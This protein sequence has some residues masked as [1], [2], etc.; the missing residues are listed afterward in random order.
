[1]TRLSREDFF[2]HEK[3]IKLATNIHKK[4]K[5]NVNFISIREPV[6]R[7][8]L[9][10]NEDWLDYIGISLKIKDKKYIVIKWELP[11]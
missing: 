10:D 2:G 4:N 8:L 6:L 5:Q 9:I 7:K 11:E 1:M 3:I